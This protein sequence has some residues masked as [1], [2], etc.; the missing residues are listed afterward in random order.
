MKRAATVV[1]GTRGVGF[2]EENTATNKQAGIPKMNRASIQTV[3]GM[4]VLTAAPC[5]YL[6]S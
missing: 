3:P 4:L 5:V 2:S 1:L 6:M